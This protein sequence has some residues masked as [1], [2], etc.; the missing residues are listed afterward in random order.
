MASG[1]SSAFGSR[2][3]G[4]SR[5]CRFHSERFAH[6]G[7]AAPEGIFSRGPVRH[8]LGDLHGLLPSVEAGMIGS[9]PA[10]VRSLL[11]TAVFS[12][13]SPPCRD[14][15]PR[16]TASRAFAPSQRVHAAHLVLQ[17]L[18]KTTLKQAPRPA[19][20]GWAESCPLSSLTKAV[21]TFNPRPPR[22][23]SRPGR[24]AL[25]QARALV[26]NA[27][28]VVAQAAGPEGDLDRPCAVLR[29][30]GDELVGDQ[31]QRQDLLGRDDRFDS[32][33][34]DNGSQDVGS[35]PHRRRR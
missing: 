11:T 27:K 33:D 20:L 32:L 2:L 12:F 28:L 13:A 22:L 14:R 18:G 24:K 31:S 29:G 4:L 35:P 17:L 30:I 7:V 8:N 19:G 23:P 25:G 16:P 3:V 1:F 5:G 10:S 6:R 21:T 15:W 9:L 26:E 34:L